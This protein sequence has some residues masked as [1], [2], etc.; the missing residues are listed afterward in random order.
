MKDLQQLVGVLAATP[1]FAQ[2]PQGPRQSI[3]AHQ[4]P[5]R[6]KKHSGMNYKSM[7]RWKNLESPV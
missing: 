3:D 2:D 6:G 4:I 1:I 5:T 7:D